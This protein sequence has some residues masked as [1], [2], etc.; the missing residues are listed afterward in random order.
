GPDFRPE[1][2][3]LRLLRELRPDVPILA[4]TATATPNVLNDIERNLGLRKPDRHVYGFYRPNLYYQV[5]TADD[6]DYK[7]RMIRQA[8]H[9]VREGRILIYCGTRN[10]T[11]EVCQEISGLRA[12]V[13]FYHAGLDTE[14]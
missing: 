7:L 6:N 3:Q 2:Y 1:Y 10:Q 5:E 12:D 9:K 11:E 8:V 14:R 13:G 4:L